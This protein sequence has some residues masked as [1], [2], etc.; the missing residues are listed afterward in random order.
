MI[1]AKKSDRPLYVKEG[2]RPGAFPSATNRLR[3]HSMKSAAPLN[4]RYREPRGLEIIGNFAKFR[5]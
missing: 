5:R 2:D 1:K 4:R 3:Q